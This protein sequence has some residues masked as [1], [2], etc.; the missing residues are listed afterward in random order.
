MT[1]VSV[2]EKQR[3]LTP[4]LQM[5]RE[6]LDA[7][8][9]TEMSKTSPVSCLPDNTVE[10]AVMLSLSPPQ[11]STA[12]QLN[13]S[14][15]NAVAPSAVSFHNERDGDH[16]MESSSQCQDTA[17]SHISATDTAIPTKTSHSGK[18]KKK[19]RSPVFCDGSEDVR[20]TSVKESRKHKHKSRLHAA[21]E[22]DERHK[23]GDIVSTVSSKDSVDNTSHSD[24][25]AKQKKSA[26]GSTHEAIVDDIVHSESTKPDKKNKTRESRENVASKSLGDECRAKAGVS[27]TRVVR[28]YRH[29]DS[30]REWT[31]TKTTTSRKKREKTS[32][33]ALSE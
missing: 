19:R 15:D 6:S 16:I 8:T 1:I 18:K 23:M 9:D 4:E 7:G 33:S 26:N 13:M 30:I 27:S 25:E 28:Q 10:Q 3:S 24:H 31:S 32:V 12:D 5:R 29:Q 17:S 2:P 22:V 11:A 21:D 14:T 20:Q